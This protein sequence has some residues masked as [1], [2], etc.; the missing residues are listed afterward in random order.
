MTP[1]RRFTEVVQTTRFIRRREVTN[2][3]RAQV[4][5]TR[6]L[7]GGRQYTGSPISMDFQNADL[8]SVLRTFAEISGLNVVIDPQVQ[9]S[10]DVALVDV[11][12]DQA[13]DIILRAN[14]LGYD[15]DGTVVRI[16]PL[17]TLADEEQQR[18]E[19][20]EQQ[21]LAGELVVLTRTLSYARASDLSDLITQAVLSSRGQVQ[22]DPRTNTVI[23]TDLQDRLGAAQ[24]LIDTLDRL[25]PQVEIEAR[26][27]Q[28]S[29]D[30]LRELGV[31]WGITGRVRAR[32]RE[33]DAAH[34]SESRRRERTSRRN[35]GA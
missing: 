32:Y 26:I 23:I 28:A 7:G 30:Y 16:A 6:T 4:T 10:V 5:Q 20:A 18:R 21:A 27:V 17:A 1:P 22:I 2:A 31:Q 24:E 14:Q 19:L 34:V 33:H 29:Q 3:P 15:V 11:P 8:R 25:E 9:G 35:S 13:L 12:W